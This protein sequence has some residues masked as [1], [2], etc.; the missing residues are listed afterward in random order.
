MLAWVTL[1]YGAT[2]SQT[3]VA[4]GQSQDARAEKPVLQGLNGQPGKS[5]AAGAFRHKYLQQK[6]Y[7]T[8]WLTASPW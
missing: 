6:V 5:Q 7:L 3:G 8:Q 2:R 4:E 1:V